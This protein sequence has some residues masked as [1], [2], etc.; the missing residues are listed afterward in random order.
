MSEQDKKKYSDF[1]N[2][3]DRN[4]FLTAEELPEG[5][6]G[7][8]VNKNEVVSNKSTPWDKGQRFHSA[9]NYPDKDSHD[10]LPRQMEG[11]HPLHD[12]EGDVE[13]QEEK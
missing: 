3:V 1:S 6:Y 13:P 10:D 5:P 2:V 12:H 4:N 8:P 7:S 11:A 9:F